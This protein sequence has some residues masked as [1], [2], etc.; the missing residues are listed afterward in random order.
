MSR[1]HY[2][3]Q[4]N[5]ARRVR[6]NK[7]NKSSSEANGEDDSFADTSAV[8]SNGDAGIVSNGDAANNC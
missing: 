3:V 1:F 2:T 4:E 7:L 6:D 5:R 8:I